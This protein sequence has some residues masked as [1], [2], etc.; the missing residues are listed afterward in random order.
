MNE[1]GGQQDEPSLP[2]DENRSRKPTYL[3][4]PDQVFV[5]M[6]SKAIEDGDRIVEYL[7]TKEKIDFIRH[8]TELTNDIHYLALQ[9]QFWQDHYDRGLKDG[10]WGMELSKSFAKEHRTCRAYSFQKKWIEEKQTVVKEEIQ[11]KLRGLQE[12]LDTLEVKAHEWEPSFDPHQLGRA[13]DAFVEK[14]QK[15]LR[16]SFQY[17]KK[18]LALNADDHYLIR[19]FYFL[20][21]EK[22]QVGGS[23]RLA[24]C[25]ES[26]LVLSCSD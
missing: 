23:R 6:L 25:I 24:L 20:E 18:M 17:R 11:L 14:G 26:C 3:K 13:I 7:N 10:F 12:D 9:Q 21:P 4:V 15:R 5:R 2:S 16:E 1:K 8:M 19:S 22:Q